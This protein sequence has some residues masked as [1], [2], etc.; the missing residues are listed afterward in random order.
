MEDVGSVLAPIP[1]CGSSADNDIEKT[2]FQNKQRNKKSK[3][4]AKHIQHLFLYYSPHSYI[5]KCCIFLSHR[6]SCIFL[7]K[8]QLSLWQLPYVSKINSGHSHCLSRRCLFP[9]PN[10]A[11]LP[12]SSPPSFMSFLFGFYFPL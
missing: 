4:A 9:N 11:H 5:A 10:H 2:D 6:H 8:N 12:A 7:F 1:N 3:W